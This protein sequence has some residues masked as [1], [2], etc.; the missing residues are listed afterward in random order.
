MNAFGLK[1]ELINEILSIVTESKSSLTKALSAFRDGNAGVFL[2]NIEF[3][4]IVNS[5]LE[6]AL[7]PY[8]SKLAE[9]IQCFA[10]FVNIAY[11]IERLENAINSGESQKAE[12]ILEFE[13]YSLLEELYAEL[14]FYLTV[15]PDKDRMKQYYENEFYVQ[16]QNRYTNIALENGGPFKYDYSF[17]IGAYNQLEYTKQCVDAFYKYTPLADINYEFI[18][19]N[20]GSTDGTEAYFDSLS[21]VKK[22]SLK[23]N[24]KTAGGNVISRAVEGRYSIGISNDV[25][26]TRNWFENLVKCIKSDAKVAIACPMTTHVSNMQQLDPGC[27]TLDEMHQFAEKYNQS[28]SSKWEERIRITP[29]VSIVDIVNYN[30]IGFTSD[31]FF[32][33]MVF[34]DDDL[35]ARLRRAGLKQILAGDT[36]CYHFGS[37]TLNQDGRE[38][39]A[40]KKQDIYLVGRDQYIE[41]YGYD[42]WANDFCFNSLFVQSVRYMGKAR[43]NILGVDSGMGGTPLQIRN[44]VRRAGCEDARLYHL[45]TN[46]LFV[47]ELEPQA[48]CFL[49]SESVRGLEGFAE[50]EFF[51]YIY[52]GSPL[53]EYGGIELSALAKLLWER[54]SEGGQLFAPFKNQNYAAH[55][56]TLLNPENQRPDPLVLHSGLEI[57]NVFGGYFEEVNL[58]YDG[59]YNDRDFDEGFLNRMMS[60]MTFGSQEQANRTA[61]ALRTKYAVVYAVKGRRH[62]D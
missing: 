59:Y 27:N 30:K 24:M 11:S 36:F 5:K 3:V 43:A 39:A 25:I 46:P 50:G 22:I 4:A 61:Q 26:V 35:S 41:K 16:H 6:M 19:F 34:S 44:V 49:Y 28:D 32:H 37:I 60:V 57:K 51:D 40:K 55:I 2:E 62:G 38:L 10:G 1:D 18:T 7:K 52:V 47:P 17:T 15:Y 14:Y 9:Y 31:R 54:M 42:P 13:L 29:P 33:H 48:D 58:Y 23:M 21:H 56:Q 20:H 45:T 53:D 8:E 12:I